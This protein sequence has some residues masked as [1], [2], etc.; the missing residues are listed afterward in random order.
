MAVIPLILTDQLPDVVAKQNSNN[1]YLNA[2][3][4][5]TYAIF[6]VGHTEPCLKSI[7]PA[8][9]LFCQGQTV[10]RTTYSD[11]WAFA[12]ASGNI[13]SE[14]TWSTTN[15]GSFSVGDGSTTFRLP[16]MRGKGL[17]GLDISQTE[18]NT[19]GKTGGE[20]SHTLLVAEVPALSVTLNW[21]QD[22]AH[23]WSSYYTQGSGTAATKG[24][25]TY[26]TNGGGGAHNNLQPYAVVNYIIVY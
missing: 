9:T 18:F 14:A 19:L 15:K 2:S 24:T 12:N 11:L 16:D 25:Y 22:T 20:K 13:V 4:S 26:P 10:S 23:D 21:S 3:L 17:I 1:N 8:Q 7:A 6:P 5:R